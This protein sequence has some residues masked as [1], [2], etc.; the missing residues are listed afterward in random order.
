MNSCYILCCIY[1]TNFINLAIKEMINNK[2]NKYLL[3][4]LRA[5]IY[6][7]INNNKVKGQKNEKTFINN[8]NC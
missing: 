3:I 6:S 1:A 4:M 8:S 7:T 5:L 2:F